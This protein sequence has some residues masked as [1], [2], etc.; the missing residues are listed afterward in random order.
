M[1][2]DGSVVIGPESYD[3]AASVASTFDIDVEPATAADLAALDDAGTKP[4]SDMKIAYVGNQDDKLSLQEL[5]FDE[6]VQ[7]TAASLNAKPALLDDVDVLW[8]GTNFN[9]ADVPASG[10]TP[11]VSFAPARAAVQAFVDG[12]GALLGRTNAA[13]NAAVSFGLMKG[14]VV[15]GNGSGNGIVAVDTP[16]DSVLAPYAQDSAFIYPAY[17]FNPGE[18]VKT[19]QTFGADPLL[20][21][22]WRPSN[23]MTPTNGPANAA[24]KA[25]VVSSENLTTGAKSMVFGTSVFFRTHTKGGM[26]QAAR[27]LFWAGPTGDAVVAPTG[28]SVSIS[29]VR[30]VTY[31]GSATVAVTAADAAGAPLNGTVEL[32]VGE[33]V[34][35]AGSTSAGTASLTVAGLRPGTTNVVARFTPSEATYTSSV[36]APAS[37]TVAKATSRLT[38][39]AQKWKKAKKARVTVSLRVPGVTTGGRIVIT[40]KGKKIKTVWVTAGR[41]R[42]VTISLRKGTHQLRATYSGSELVGPSTSRTVKVK[43]G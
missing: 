16:A 17:W 9:T 18:G 19:E 33:S 32:L 2:A 5:G 36:S 26:S 23:A 22:H 4:L 21:G 34:I 41:G 31:P 13:F 14:S 37:I 11:A 8:V 27:G 7:L 29:P 28:S 35:A 3:A 43:I 12:G 20:A 38:L 40:D 1:L 25:S 15:N 6:L 42:T 10:T 24:G 39:K 30:S